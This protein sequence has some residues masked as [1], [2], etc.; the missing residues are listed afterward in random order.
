MFL[1]NEKQTWI[2]FRYERLPNLCYWCGRLTHDDKDC[3]MWI[4]SEGTLLPDLRQFGP[5]IHAPTFISLRKNAITVL[6]FYS[7]KKTGTSSN[8][9]VCDSSGQASVKSTMN[10]PVLVTSNHHRS[11]KLGNRLDTETSE[12]LSN[13]CPGVTPINVPLHE[14]I[15]TNSN[16]IN[17]INSH[18]IGPDIGVIN[19]INSQSIGPDKGVIN[20]LNS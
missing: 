3:Q 8:S 18:S 5:S 19:G 12:K 7:S 9:M 10:P 20:G 15:P 16:V 11:S 13:A 6:G 17:G 4:E 1:K 2:S 14:L